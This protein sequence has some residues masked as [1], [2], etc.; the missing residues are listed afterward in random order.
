MWIPLKSEGHERAKSESKFMDG[1]WLGLRAKSD[2][3][4]IGTP[5]GVVRAHSVKKV[6]RR[7]KVGRRVP[8]KHPRNTPRTY[9]R[10]GVYKGTSEAKDPGEPGP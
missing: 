3:D 6:A 1:V 9:S 2:E 4:L 8:Q 5:S 7:S 10:K